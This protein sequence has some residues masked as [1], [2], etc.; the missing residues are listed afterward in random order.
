M[1]SALL[2]GSNCLSEIQRKYNPI[3]LQKYLLDRKA[4]HCAV[5]RQINMVIKFLIIFAKT[6]LVALL[7]CALGVIVSNH[8]AVRRFRKKMPGMPIAPSR[9]LFNNHWGDFSYKRGTFKIFDENHLKLGKTFALFLNQ[10]V[11]FSTVDL[12]FIKRMML[13]EGNTNRFYP[14]TPVH[15]IEQDSLIKIA[16]SQWKRVRRVYASALS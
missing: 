14:S 2:I 9:N 12:D 7:I 5:S 15:E 16:D 1:N 8:L 4:S 11:S 13:D 10:K 6:W 3:S